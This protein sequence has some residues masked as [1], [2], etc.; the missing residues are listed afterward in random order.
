[1]PVPIAFE[2]PLTSSPKHEDTAFG[3]ECRL[4]RSLPF[5]VC[6]SLVAAL[7]SFDTTTAFADQ[8]ID[9]LMEHFSV[10]YETPK[11]TTW[12]TPKI[13]ETSE[14][15]TIFASIGVRDD[16]TKTM[17]LNL[18]G[19]ILDVLLAKQLSLV[20]DN[21]PREIPVDRADHLIR[22]NSSASGLMGTL[23]LDDQESLIRLIA[24][25][26]QVSVTLIGA[27][28]QHPKELRLPQGDLDNF[29]R[30]VAYYDVATL[31]SSNKDATEIP[32][33]SGHYFAGGGGV[34]NPQLLP[35]SKVLPKYPEEGAKARVEGQ[36]SFFCL[37]SKDGSVEEFHVVKA[38]AGGYGFAESAIKAV[39]KWRYK[40][41]LMDGKPV[42]AY[43]TVIVDFFL[44]H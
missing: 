22:G 17:V 34:T 37:V 10:F 35:K 9:Q 7:A 29:R 26:S 15:S 39:R 44:H 13:D 3:G 38:P 31:P 8:T 30:I 21:K 41:A 1:M 43:F 33:V 42:D 16:G 2:E 24:G 25:A 18:F 23:L 19:P 11:Q 32:E 28:W 12:Y 36:V 4:C 27:A 5:V 20:I 40:P 6:I 14:G